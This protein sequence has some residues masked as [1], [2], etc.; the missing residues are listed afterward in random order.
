MLQHP[1]PPALSSLDHIVGMIVSSR[2]F[3]R[4]QD[5]DKIMMNILEC[6]IFAVSSDSRVAKLLVDQTVCL[7]RRS[8]LHWLERPG[9][10]RAV[11]PGSDLV[12]MLAILDCLQVQNMSL[13]CCSYIVKLLGVKVFSMTEVDQLGIGRV[14]EETSDY[15]CTSVCHLTKPNKDQ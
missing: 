4:E 10:S 11:R 5:I 6:D 8:C 2:K 14:M 3:L 1:Q 15:L 7:C 13:L 9:R 12:S